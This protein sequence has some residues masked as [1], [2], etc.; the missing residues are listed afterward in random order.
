MF[1]KKK[2]SDT[3]ENEVKKAKK[4]KKPRRERKKKEPRPK[5]EKKE[6]K[7]KEPKEP[8][9]PKKP[10]KPKKPKPPKRPK[11][12]KPKKPKKKMNPLILVIILLVILVAAAAG[13]LVL[14]M[15]QREKEEDDMYGPMFY[16]TEEDGIESIRSKIGDREIKGGYTP[17][18]DLTAQTPTPETEEDPEE[19]SEESEEEIEDERDPELA[20]VDIKLLTDQELSY[21]TPGDGIKEAE[22]YITYLV[23]EKGFK[24]LTYPEGSEGEIPKEAPQ[25]TPEAED[26][27][28]DKKDKDKEKDKDKD[29]DR[30]EAP[31][32]EEEE[33]FIPSEEG[34]YIAALDNKSTVE[35]GEASQI[36][37][38][39]MDYTYDSY[40]LRLSTANGVVNDLIPP[41]PEE[42]EETGP[43]QNTL[44]D[45]VETLQR[46]P[47]EILQL[48][49][50]TVEYE[51]TPIQGRV[52]IEG[53]DF[54]NVRAYEK[55]EGDS[56]LYG[57]TY[58]VSAEGESVYRHDEMTG[59][60][61][62][63]SGEDI[64][65]QA[66]Q[67]DQDAAVLSGN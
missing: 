3:E 24:V 20:E 62:C 65:A 19:E 50:P 46:M 4:D 10:K 59:E 66:R 53:I 31:E 21:I 39:R 15:K 63:I 30:E 41:E 6:K 34:Y 27:D 28:K 11:P 1:G 35:E 54:F 64:I 60:T 57:G 8:K 37:R 7:Q 49:K 22:E 38:V 40:T 13:A 56:L 12:K 2:S 55:G 44:N 61:T 17:P 16:F 58:Y 25:P 18:V 43:P 9:R 33:G 42:E 45:A 32:E 52:V 51:M 5:K 23:Q 14:M 29:E 47:R 36:K 26:G 67:Q 48:T